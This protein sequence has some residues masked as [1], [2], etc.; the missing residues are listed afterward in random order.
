[1]SVKRVYLSDCFQA[2]LKVKKSCE[3][4]GKSGES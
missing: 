2:Y 3:I 1:M 4:G